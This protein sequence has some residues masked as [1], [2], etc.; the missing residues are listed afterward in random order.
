MAAQGPS[1]L[2]LQTPPTHRPQSVR[3]DVGAWSGC[4]Q[5]GGGTA[6]A[7]ACDSSRAASDRRSGPSARSGGSSAPAADVVAISDDDE[8][9]PTSGARLMWSSLKALYEGNTHL[10]GRRLDEA[11][12]V[13]AGEIR[14]YRRE[15]QQ[16]LPNK[17]KYEH[18]PDALGLCVAKMFFVGSV[19][20]SFRP[21][22]SPSI[23]GQTRDVVLAKMGM[24]PALASTSARSTSP[25]RPMPPPL[26]PHSP[27]VSAPS[28]STPHTKA[29]L[30]LFETAVFTEDNFH[31]RQIQVAREENQPVIQLVAKRRRRWE[32]NSA[33][34]EAISRSIASTLTRGHTAAN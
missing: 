15:V 26:S 12:A 14:A 32:E 30:K 25:P 3:R 27:S 17:P 4:R 21:H 31:K 20:T 34:M 9:A 19:T 16:G 11:G 2:P 28:P 13:F 1:R 22:V 5:P 6:R 23:A 7:P 18:T 8:R 24:G 29:S 33:Q 10:T